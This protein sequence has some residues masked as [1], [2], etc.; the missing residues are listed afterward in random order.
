MYKIGKKG[1]LVYALFLLGIITFMWGC[2][3]G[4]LLFGGWLVHDNQMNAEQ[5]TYFIVTLI[6][7]LMNFMM[8]AG[9][10]GAVMKVRGAATKLS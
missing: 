2:F 1:A 6:Q 4:V 10:L 8:L 5:I 3:V 7:L 9:V